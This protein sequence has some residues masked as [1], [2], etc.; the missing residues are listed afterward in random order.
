MA[1]AFAASNTSRIPFARAT[2]AWEA[3]ALFGVYGLYF[4]L[5]EGVEKALVADLA[6]ADDRGAAFGWYHLI[7]GLGALP[8]SALFGAMWV[9][10]G[11]G[12]AFNLG[13]ALA[14]VAGV[15]LMQL[16]LPSARVA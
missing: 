10:R 8:A 16:R 6:S 7:V 15:A 3:W 11:P 5:T 1:S 2:N 4:G 9:W 13:A 12:A 14:L